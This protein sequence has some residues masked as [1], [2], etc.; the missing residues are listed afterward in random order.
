MEMR[1]E[2]STFDV[3]ISY[4][5]S[6]IRLARALHVALERYE[7]PPF[8][9]RQGRK[10]AVFRD[11]T[12]IRGT[13]YYQSIENHLRASRK[14]LVVCSPAARKS[15]YVHDEIRRFLETN[16]LENVIPIIAS[17]QPNNEASKE[18]SKAFPALLGDLALAADLTRFEPRRHR[19]QD[20]DWDHQRHFILANILD[21]SR[22]V[23]EPELGARDESAR[24]EA[25]RLVTMANAKRDQGR[26]AEALLYVAAA[27]AIVP[28][29]PLK[30]SLGIATHTQFPELAVDTILPLDLPL[31]GL[32]FDAAGARLI[33]WGAEGRTQL[34]DVTT[35][36][37]L[38]RNRHPYDVFGAA[39]LRDGS[40]VTYSLDGKVVVLNPG[41]DP[42]VWQL[43]HSV[44]HIVEAPVGDLLAFI[45]RSGEVCLWSRAE[46]R[47]IAVVDQFFD[48]ELKRLPSLL[49]SA[50]GEILIGTNGA[51]MVHV[52]RAAQGGITQL[53]AQYVVQQPI[54]E[55]ESFLVSDTDN[56]YL[57]HLTPESHAVDVLTVVRRT[58]GLTT[59]KLGPNLSRLCWIEDGQRFFTRDWFVYVDPSDANEDDGRVSAKLKAET[60]SIHFWNGDAVAVAHGEQSAC[61]VAPDGRTL[62]I[63]EFDYSSLR[64]LGIELHSDFGLLSQIDAK[65]TRVTY[66]DLATGAHEVERPI[67]PIV[68]VTSSGDGGCLTTVSGEGALRLRTRR[69][70]SASRAVKR[71]YDGAHVIQHGPRVVVAFELW[72][73]GLLLLDAVAGEPAF[74]PIHT[75]SRFSSIQLGPRG[76]I[77]SALR[78][79]TQDRLRLWR[80]IDAEAR[81]VTLPSALPPSVARTSVSDD[82]IAV[83]DGKR[84]WTITTHPKSEILSQMTYS[85]DENIRA[86]RL[87]PNN[88]SVAASTA[89]GFQL[90]EV[91]SGRPVGD[92]LEFEGQLISAEF[93]TA[94]KFVACG[95]DNSFVVVDLTTGSSFRRTHP[96]PD[97][98]LETG[99]WALRV[100]A[101]GTLLFTTGPDRSMRTWD[102]ETGEEVA[103]PARHPFQL[104]GLAP[105]DNTER[106][107]TWGGDTVAVWNP[108]TGAKVGPDIEVDGMVQSAF[109]TLDNERVAISEGSSLSLYDPETGLRIAGPWEHGGVDVHAQFVDDALVTWT[110]DGSVSVWALGG[111]KTSV[112]DWRPAVERVTALSLDVDR[113]LVLPLTS[114]EH[115][116]VKSEST[117]RLLS[118]VY[119][120]K[121]ISRARALSWFPSVRPL[122]AA[123]V[124]AFFVGEEL[125]DALLNPVGRPSATEPWYADGSATASNEVVV[126]PAEGLMWQVEASDALEL[127]QVTEYIHT[128][129]RARF[130]GFDDWRVPRLYEVAATLSPQINGKLHVVRGLGGQPHIWTADAPDTSD[131]WGVD[132]RAGRVVPMPQDTAHHVRLVRFHDV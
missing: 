16:T 101:D 111:A 42:V 20:P 96:G 120:G 82:V 34:L 104:Q 17:G 27:H 84:I 130:A 107:I 57:L 85:G 36:K 45:G 125:F 86:L 72:G 21:V 121:R 3:F 108:W 9:R 95:L 64:G 32:R 6:D 41:V 116:L 126:Q 78:T 66:F 102:I 97:T 127:G 115:E 15:Q 103:E 14:L 91:A 52:D 63:H 65:R 113:G 98:I 54:A 92:R 60:K 2:Q 80:A 29:S 118:G 23:F 131:V 117:E 5:H 79:G 59:A 106:I 19:L 112:G 33:A 50:A 93:T 26:R 73:R 61:A 7:V 87:G 77:L 122:T 31:R 4:S 39:F 51:V 53:P 10:I 99:I 124:Q 11:E 128:M 58:P 81:E 83:T 1:P 90:W 114:T 76:E 55:L 37:V 18:E 105:S 109:W 49:F 110:K 75:A 69:S 62:W 8:V 67:R 48:R 88:T 35:G 22:D 46:S 119:S 40:A 24:A 56:L 94:E 47:R 13:R 123:V 68:G 89:R 74:P 30:R 28:N 25:L 71:F 100:S 70:K 129:N 132:Y 43:P 44:V 38:T 12:D